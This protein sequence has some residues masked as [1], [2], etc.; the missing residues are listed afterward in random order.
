[1]TGFSEEALACF[2]RYVWPG[3]IASWRNVVE[4]ALP[5][6]LTEIELSSP[7]GAAPARPGRRS[8]APQE[9]AVLS[10]NAKLEVAER[11]YLISLLESHRGT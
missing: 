4:R 6:T 7:A 10:R 2:R 8:G 1:V 11:E 3:N 5:G 9:Q